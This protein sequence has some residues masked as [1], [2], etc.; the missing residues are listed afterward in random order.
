[1]VTRT[2]QIYAKSAFKIVTES[3]G[4]T[5]QSDIIGAGLN[6]DSFSWENPNDVKFT[7]PA[8]TVSLTF[9]DSDGELTDDPFS[10]SNV[11][12]QQLSEEVTINGKTYSPSEETVRWESNPPVNVEN[13]YEI[14][15]FDD[16]GNTYRMV[17]VSITE[18]YNT[19]VVGIM[20][21]GPQPPPGTTLHYRQGEST[22]SGTGQSVTIPEESICFLAGTLIETPAGP[23]AVETLRAGDK[24]LTLDGGAKLL[25]WIGSSTLHARGPL[26]PIRIRAGAIGNSRDLLVS[27]NHR[28]LLRSPVAQLFFGDAEILVPAKALVDGRTVVPSPMPCA[29]YF[30]LLF[31]THEMV[32]SE[33]IAA[34]SLFTGEVALGALNA[35]AH[36]ELRAAVPTSELVRQ[37][38]CRPAL[39]PTETELLLSAIGPEERGRLGVC[40]PDKAMTRRRA[41]HLRAA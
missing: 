9:D 27:P 8:E 25:R 12:D 39:T 37:E 38:L 31:D 15:L 2:I 16:D 41:R 26:A 18:G 35:A 36:A 32:Y 10:G 13:E 11:V 21:D 4:A 33:G 5:S 14:T 23:V 20:F 30:H 34:E 29:R 24:I 28:I 19:E 1:M 7:V 6:G 17:G 3:G 22:Y 40:L